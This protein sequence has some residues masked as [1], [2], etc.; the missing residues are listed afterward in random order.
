M[1]VQHSLKLH[2][3]VEPIRKTPY[4]MSQVQK[5]ALHEELQ[6]FLQKGWIRP[7][8]SPWA[9]VALV[10][11]KKDQTWRMCIDYR[12]LNSVTIMD[13]YPLPKIDELLNRLA[14]ARIFSKVDLHSGFH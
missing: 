1:V 12:D 13:A 14:K 4:R 10:V 2:P 8:K 7:S 5:M 3:G 6:K 11:P 9:T